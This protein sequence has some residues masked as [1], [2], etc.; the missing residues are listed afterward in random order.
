MQILENGNYFSIKDIFFPVS[1][2]ISKAHSGTG[3]A[4]INLKPTVDISVVIS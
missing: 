2:M 1:L 3:K 4:F